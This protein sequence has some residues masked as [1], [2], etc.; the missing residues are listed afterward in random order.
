[1]FAAGAAVLL[2]CSVLRHELFQSSAYDLGWFD[3]A[4]YLISR[5]EA[6]TVSLVGHHILGDHAA[7]VLYLLAPLYVIHASV[8]WLLAA[9]ATALAG[10]AWLVWVLGRDA[11]LAPRASLGIAA[12]VLLYPLVLNLALFDF[13]PEALAV[14]GVLAAVLA[15]QRRRPL[16]FGAALLLVLGSKEV[17]ALN[18]IALGAWL[19]VARR[20]RAYGVAA[21]LAGA[22]WFVVATQAVIPRYSGREA[23][24]LARYASF[25]GT[26][27]EVAAGVIARP[28]EVASRLLSADALRYLAEVAVP[29]AWGLSPAHL[30]PLV[31]AAPTVALNLLAD[32]PKQRSLL[33]Q[34]S[35]PVLPFLFLAVV[36]ARAAGRGRPR[37][38]ALALAWSLAAFLAMAQYDRF[39]TRYVD[40]LDTW[41]A[42]RQAL[43][44]IT[45]DG[46]V[47]TTSDLVPHLAHRGRIEMTDA[48]APAPDVTAFSWVLLDRRRPGWRGSDELTAALLHALD[49]APGFRRLLERDGIV[50]FASG[51]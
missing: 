25:G 13:H 5:G 11:G 42:R 9:Q 44:L 10:A 30:A 1:L 26:T 15:A 39:W 17:L 31:G 37:R 48:S 51:S 32:Y 18:V 50:L 38:G 27:A 20:R 49:A 7:F 46:P 6:P 2:A 29:V 23:A 47:L 4:V 28:G 24:G 21:A 41:R 40:S 8:Y 16:W 19:A 22:A 45:G 43:A 14:P 36:S 35:A 33:Y 12:T 3:Q 34:Y